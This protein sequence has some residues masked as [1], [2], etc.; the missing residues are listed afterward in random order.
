MFLMSCHGEGCGD[1]Q[2]H[3]YTGGDVSKGVSS[4]NVQRFRNWK[5]EKGRVLTGVLLGVR[6]IYEY[7]KDTSLFPVTREGPFTISSATK[8]PS[9]VVCVLMHS[10]PHQCW[11]RWD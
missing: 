1:Y 10:C 5:G 9:V 3:L 8:E 4:S 6:L 2:L 7:R 11:E